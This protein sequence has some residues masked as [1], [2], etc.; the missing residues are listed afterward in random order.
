MNKLVFNRI[1]PATKEMLIN[2]TNQL[3]KEHSIEGLILGGT[4]LSL[5]LKQSDFDN[6]SVFDSTLIHVASLVDIMIG[7]N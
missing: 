4:E 7:E 5:I 6:L 2:I 3:K 1:N